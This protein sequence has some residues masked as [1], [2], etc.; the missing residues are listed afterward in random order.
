MSKA[1]LTHANEIF[2][3]DAFDH[4]A[5]AHYGRKGIPIHSAYFYSFGKVA[6]PDADGYAEAQ[7]VA[8]AKFSTLNGALAGKADVARGLTVKSSD[9]G[10]TAQTVKVIGTD[11]YGN[12]VSET[13]TLN[14]TTAVN[15][16]KAFK[17]VTSAYVSA[18]MTGNLTIGTTDVLGLP[19]VAATKSRIIDVFFNDAK[20]ASATIVVAN[21]TS[22]ATAT[23]GDVRGTIDPNTACD[24]LKE[25]VV[26]MVP[27]PTN[28]FGV[29]QFAG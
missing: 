28:P 12:P 14:G 18:A 4:R 20:D 9:V 3:G 25:V 19:F 17:T 23:T 21:A 15:G 5:F 13:L 16:K 7:A 10:D 11:F 8:A 29:A 22:P 26:I 6:A 1:H 24:G 27:D 2:H